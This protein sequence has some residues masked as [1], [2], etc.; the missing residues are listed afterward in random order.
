MSPDF[1]MDFLLANVNG[2][3]RQKLKIKSARLC[4]WQ[5]LVFELSKTQHTI[6]E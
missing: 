1:N 3:R 5:S 6:W 4:E 2:E